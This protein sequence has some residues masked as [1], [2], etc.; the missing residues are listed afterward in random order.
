MLIMPNNS[1][2]TMLCLVRC[3]FDIDCLTYLTLVCVKEL[4]KYLLNYIMFQMNFQRRG[5]IL[6][7]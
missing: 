3:E 1:K 6:P 7:P 4:C 5:T 2:L